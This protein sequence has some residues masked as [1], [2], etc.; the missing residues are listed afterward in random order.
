MGEVSVN[1]SMNNLTQI[2]RHQNDA[3]RN[4]V[5]HQEQ[6]AQLARDDAAKRIT[7]PIE[8]DALEK[9][10][11][12]P[13]DRKK[14]NSARKRKRKNKGKDEKNFQNSANSENIIDMRV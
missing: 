9:K 4:P 10:D 13:N 6:N 2:D 3:H 5:V 8:P 12:D 14:E 11:V 7:M 1:I